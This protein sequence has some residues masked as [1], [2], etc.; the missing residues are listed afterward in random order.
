MENTI[1]YCKGNINY[2][3]IIR[4][5]KD[6]LKRVLVFIIIFI[7]LIFVISSNVTKVKVLI[8]ED[9]TSNVKFE[10]ESYGVGLP[11]L[12]EEGE[13]EVVDGKFIVKMKRVYDKLNMIIS[14]IPN[15]FICIGNKKIELNNIL[16][17]QN[18]SITIYVGEIYKINYFHQ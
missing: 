4:I 18:S 2:M 17:K 7:S 10:Y 12:S 13:L 3:K 8:I 14:P 6:I 15:H 5:K 16:K 1:L 9:N 11:F